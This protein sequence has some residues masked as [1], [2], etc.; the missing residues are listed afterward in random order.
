[1]RIVA[2]FLALAMWANS[3]FMAPAQNRNPMDW[4]W[5]AMMLS[6]WISPWLWMRRGWIW[7][8]LYLFSLGI[9]YYFVHLNVGVWV[10]QWRWKGATPFAQWPLRLQYAVL[11]GTLAALMALWQSV[12]LSLGRVRGF[13]G[14]GWVRSHRIPIGTKNKKAI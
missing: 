10:V 9:S 4:L 2:L 3:V 11:C 5:S 14:T 6:I 1:M 13:H 7:W 8:P 12:A